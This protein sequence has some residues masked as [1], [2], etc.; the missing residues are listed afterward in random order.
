MFQ[1]TTAA[2]ERAHD[3]A[4]P[5]LDEYRS[6]DFLESTTVDAEDGDMVGEIRSTNSTW[7]DA[8]AWLSTA[9]DGEPATG[10]WAVLP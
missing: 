7:A 3:G 1:V 10:I 2:Y 6:W 8:M 4:R 9:P 5:A